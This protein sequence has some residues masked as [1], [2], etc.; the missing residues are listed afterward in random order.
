MG[1]I[2][3]TPLVFP[4]QGTALAGVLHRNVDNLAEPQPAAIVIS[5]WL[6][7]KEQMAEVYARR[8]AALGLTAF[9]FDFAGFGCGNHSTHS[10]V[11]VLPFTG[12]GGDVRISRTYTPLTPA[13]V[14]SG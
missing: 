1:E 8:L 12:S 4:S 5:S 7:V 6:T 10:I 9:T 14:A 3:R 11:Y 2:F 13:S